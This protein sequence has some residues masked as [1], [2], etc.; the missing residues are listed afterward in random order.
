[1]V[2]RVAG[3]SEVGLYRLSGENRIIATLREGLDNGLEPAAVLAN[4]DVHNITGLFKL[5]LREMPEPLIPFELYDSF[6]AANGITEYDARLY[7]IR[8]LVWKMPKPN[9]RL[10]RRL[11]E[12]LDK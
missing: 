1:M 4:V 10:L 12:H 6:I 8:D 9:F 11:M 7:A 3:L 2:Y 5:F